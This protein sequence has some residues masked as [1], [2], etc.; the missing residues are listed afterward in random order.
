MTRLLV[1]TMISAMA[2]G[3]AMAQ[4]ACKAV[5]KD[6]KPLAGAAKTSHMKKCCTGKAVGADGKPLTGAA[7][8]SSITKCMAD[9]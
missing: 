1:A 4:E 9:G 2:L 3:S 8:E 6:G 7:K 5:S